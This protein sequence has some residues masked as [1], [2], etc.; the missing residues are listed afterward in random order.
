MAL[1]CTLAHS[2][3]SVYD[4]YIDEE[5][6]KLCFNCFEIEDLNAFLKS[7][8]ISK[9]KWNSGTEIILLGFNRPAVMKYLQE[10]VKNE[11]RAIE[12]EYPFRILTFFCPPKN[13]LKETKKTKSPENIASSPGSPEAGSPEDEESEAEESEASEAGSDSDDSHHS[14]SPEAGSPEVGSDDES[15][16]SKEDLN[17]PRSPKEIEEAI[18]KVESKNKKSEK[19]SSRGKISNRSRRSIYNDDS[20]EGPSSPIA[21]PIKNRGHTA[22][23]RKGRK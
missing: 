10:N 23:R 5:H 16:H 3:G 21:I 4:G 14:A 6:D 8:N 2:V 17:S 11:G 12:S 13:P 15:H 22:R 18:E 7:A 9:K 1:I 19:K 20:D